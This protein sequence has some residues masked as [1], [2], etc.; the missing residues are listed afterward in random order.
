MSASV[1]APAIRARK[2]DGTPLVMVTAY[3]TPSARISR[4]ALRTV[5][6]RETW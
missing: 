6:S 3:D 5:S 2:G 4:A 1:A